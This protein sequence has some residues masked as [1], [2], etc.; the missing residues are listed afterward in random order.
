[1]AKKYDKIRIDVRFPSAHTLIVSGT[2][3]AG[4]KWEQ[5]PKTAVLG[6]QTALNEAVASAKE[7]QA[8]YPD[9]LVFVTGTNGQQY[10]PSVPAAE[11][12]RPSRKPIRK[13]SRRRSSRRR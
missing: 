4:D 8:K 7:Y 6:L 12:A 11:V 13:N 5:T 2:K 10:W 9:A 3:Y 1:V